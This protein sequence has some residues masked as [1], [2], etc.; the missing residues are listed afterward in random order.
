M[1][2][3]TIQEV[4]LE[5][6]KA[7]IF[8]D[9][10][11][12]VQWLFE[13]P[14][15]DSGWIYARVIELESRCAFFGEIWNCKKKNSLHGEN[16]RYAKRFIAQ[17]V[18]ASFSGTRDEARAAFD[19][20]ERFIIQRSKERS[21][22]WLNTTMSVLGVISFIALL[23]LV[24]CANH[25]LTDLKYLVLACGAAGGVGACV[26]RH[27]A[28]RVDL[29]CEAN[30]GRGLHYLEAFM[31]WGAGSLAGSLISLLVTSKALLGNLDTNTSNGLAFTVAM[32]AF[33]GLSERLL[34]A[35]RE[36]AEKELIGNDPS[37]QPPSDGDADA[38]AKA[39][40]AAAT[41]KV[42]EEAAAAAAEA[43]EEAAAAT[44]KV[45]EEAAAAA[46]EAEEE[47]AAAAAKVRE[48]E[49]AAARAKAEE[50][51]KPDDE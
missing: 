49:E 21:L 15:V 22:I 46:A 37:P 23:I 4:I 34:P 5:T 11:H 3:V 18:A 7:F 39:A 17:G 27:L 2:G 19:S 30:A 48:E 42:E 10:E 51:K 45:E 31:R 28:N 32:A 50:E 40:A 29:P 13:T 16:F 33:A 8:L 14:P 12:R 24:F 44:A 26:S 47:A 25:P 35:L 43:E 9:T 38:A 6:D 36:K 41:A 20:A 1:L